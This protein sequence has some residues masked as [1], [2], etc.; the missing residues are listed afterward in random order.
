MFT[1]CIAFAR[2]SEDN[3]RFRRLVLPAGFKAA[4]A[5]RRSHAGPLR[6]I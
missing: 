4:S 5:R 1:Q 2:F 3:G 6:P